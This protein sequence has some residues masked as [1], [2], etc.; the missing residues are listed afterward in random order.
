[1]TRALVLVIIASV[2]G[3][4]EAAPVPKGGPKPKTLRVELDA[5]RL[6]TATTLQVRLGLH[7]SVADV[8]KFAT[9]ARVKHLV[10][11][12]HDP[13]HTDE[14]VDRFVSGLRSLVA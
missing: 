14:D 10:P 5:Y 9:M 7:S 13:G 12:H 2:L 4:L 8:L 1:M 11:F 6:R 3:Q